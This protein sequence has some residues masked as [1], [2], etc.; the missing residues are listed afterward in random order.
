[1]YAWDWLCWAFVFS[2][3]LC[4][5]MIIGWSCGMVL[6]YGLSGLLFVEGI[7]VVH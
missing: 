3:G 5:G 6:G 7:C 4:R 1:M 2:I